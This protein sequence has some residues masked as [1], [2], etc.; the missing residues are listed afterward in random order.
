MLRTVVA[1]LTQAA[2]TVCEEM[3]KLGLPL[4]MGKTCFLCSSQALLE[5]LLDEPGWPFDESFCA[6]THHDLGGDATDGKARRVPTQAA[7]LQASAAAATRLSKIGRGRE[8]GRA[9]RSGP[10]AKATWGAH[11]M[12]LG[13]SALRALRVA[14]VRSMG[15]L[16]QGS[17]RQQNCF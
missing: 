1:Q 11:I 6:S 10:V 9:H 5:A 15:P 8:A 2:L 14:S 17:S 3:D 4:N 7:R 16:Q 12:G 13:E